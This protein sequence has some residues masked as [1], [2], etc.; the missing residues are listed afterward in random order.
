MTTINRRDTLRLGL[1][2]GI[3]AAVLSR[4]AAW[5]ADA[6]KV[7]FL[8]TN[9]L[10]DI[11]EEKGRGGMARLAAIVKSERAK[12]PN[13]VFAH[14]GDSFSPSLLSGFDQGAHMVDLLN[15]VAPDVFV[16]GNHEFDFGKETFLK[17][18]AEARF[19]IFS[20]NL[21]GPGG[22]SV[23]KVRPSAI[24]EFGGVRVGILGSTLETTGQLSNSG[25]F[26]F[27]PSFETVRDEAK[28]LR[29]KGADF[30]VAVVHTDRSTDLRMFDAKL[31]D[32]I[33]TGHDHDLRV[34]F[35]GKVAMAES[36]ED[37]QYVVAVDVAMT[38]K[39]DGGK[40]T[41]AWWPEFRII[42]TATVTPDP[43]MTRRVKSYEDE[44]SHELDV[45]V[46]T[47]AVEFDS[48]TA[49]V[50]SQETAIGNLVADSIRAATRADVALT[51]GGGIRGNKQYP[52]GSAL[53]RRDILTELPFGNRTT[54]TEIT[55]ASLRR[56]L[57]N[58]FSQME[59]KAGRF[60]QV[61]NLK[62]VVE[63]TRPAGQRVISVE[64]GGEPLD[65]ARTYKVATNDFMLRGG[66]GYTALA[67]KVAATVD[68]GGAL[69]ANDVMSHARRLGTISL[70]PEGRI[71]VR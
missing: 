28:A 5:A 12:S 30:V 26:V 67:G 9:D 22:A 56:A 33:L 62:I 13:V 43:D 61:S 57:E 58:G 18:I 24:M 23:D 17:R 6:V 48:R 3:S 40:R 65:D 15:D 14:A 59:N 54:T 7:T 29:E 25:D 2:A 47:L 10:Y 71:V 1:K 50:R 70:K 27:R 44:L 49:S 8:L 69:L 64:V 63:S 35:D 20:A 4:G 31:A 53:T 36:G 60:P 68:S 46:A 16:P 45:S 42:D 41:L 34:V 39:V 52:A 32:L 38:L 55:G 11:S 19:P 51:N 21:S 66:D 37:A